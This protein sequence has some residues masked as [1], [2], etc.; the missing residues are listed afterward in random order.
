MC[1]PGAADKAAKTVHQRGVLRG[2]SSNF[3]VAFSAFIL[4]YSSIRDYLRWSMALDLLLLGLA[5]P[6]LRA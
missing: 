4:Y 6:L 2:N 3:L 5:L 1:C